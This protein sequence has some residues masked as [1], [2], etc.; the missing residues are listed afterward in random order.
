MRVRKQKKEEEVMIIHS[1]L[2][3]EHAGQLCGLSTAS[4]NGYAMRST[5]LFPPVPFFFV[6]IVFF[7]ALCH[8]ASLYQS[9]TLL[10]ES[11]GPLLFSTTHVHSHTFFSPSIL[12]F[13]FFSFCPHHINLTPPLLFRPL[14]LSA[15]LLSL[16]YDSLHSFFLPL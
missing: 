12:L 1:I 6:P 11:I 15:Y 5:F 9:V 14:P 13:F 7:V 4:P 2:S 16:F 3:Q 10:Q 8:F